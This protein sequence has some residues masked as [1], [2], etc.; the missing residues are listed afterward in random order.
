MKKALSNLLFVMLFL[1]GCNQSAKNGGHTTDS[2]DQQIEVNGVSFDPDNYSH[3]DIVFY[4]LFSP[5]DLSY[6]VSQSNS[7]Y[8]SSFLNPLNNITKYSSSTQIALNL[9]VYGADLSYLWMFK[10]SQQALSYLAAI[11]RLSDQLE[12]PREF[13]DFTFIK[14]E[15]KADNADSLIK[16]ARES[17]YLSEKYLKESGRDHA[18][19]LILLGGWIETMHIATKMYPE[20]DG[21]AAGRI[22]AQQFSLNSLYTLLMNYQESE[23]LSEYTLLLKKL[24]NTYEESGIVFPEGSLL[25]DTL[26]RKIYVTPGSE[27]QF[28]VEDA[29]RITTRVNSIRNHI[30]N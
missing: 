16:I 4:N 24:K 22:A 8:N 19:A 15:G 6:L 3:E 26:E 28:S 29:K 1:T 10:Q 21:E 2:I 30:I 18:A 27:I 11:Q 17:Y 7:F 13:V 5:V 9:G 25:I 23:D 12:I 14:A 20:P